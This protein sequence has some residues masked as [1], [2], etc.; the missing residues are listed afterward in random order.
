MGNP[1][2]F[3]RP[4]SVPNGRQIL[5]VGEGR[6]WALVPDVRNNLL[7]LQSLAREGSA[8]AGVY[9]DGR[10][11]L[12]PF[13]PATTQ[14]AILLD[15]QG[16]WHFAVS[17][18]TGLFYQVRDHDAVAAGLARRT[19]LS[20]PAKP[21]L[22]SGQLGDMALLPG[23]DA[24]SL[25]YVQADGS[26]A[27]V[28]LAVRR[29][30]WRHYEM[31]RGQGFRPPALEVAEDRLLLTWSDSAGR[32]YFQ[33]V[34]GTSLGKKPVAPPQVI[35]VPGRRP[36]IMATDT[37]VFVAYED[38]WGQVVALV[39]E[40]EAWPRYPLA[41]TTPRL[42]VDVTHSAHLVRDTHGVVW[43][44]FSDA[45]RR[46]TYFTRWLG[47]QWSEVYDARGIFQ[48]SP[49]F[50]SNLLSADYL[51]VEK[52]P[53]GG[54]IGM[55][56]VNVSSAVATFETVPVV[57]PEARPGQRVLFLDMLEVGKMEG[58]E[59]VLV[60]A[61]KDEANPVFT[62]D[63]DRDAFDHL[64]VF[65][66]GTVLF[67]PA[68]RIYR[69]WYSGMRPYPE[70]IAWWHWLRGGYAESDDGRNWRRINLG[71]AEWNG[72]IENNL[73]PDFPICPCVYRDDADA[74]PRRRYKMLHFL[75]AG[76]QTDLAAAGG[77][78]LDAPYYPG[79][80]YT[81]PDGLR[82]SREPA[83]ITF[84]E[85]R[86]LSFVPQCFFRDDADPDPQ[87]RWKAY[88]FMSV[89]YRR[90]AGGFAYSPEALHWT[91]HPRNPV[92]EPQTSRLPM[93]PAGRLSQI[94]DMVVWREGD[95]YLGLFQDQ[96]SP[97][98]M[99]LELAV[100][101]DGEHFVYPK[102]GEPFIAEGGAGRWDNREL[103]PS[104]PLRVGDE[105][106]FYYGG[107]GPTP[108][109]E[110]PNDLYWT[111]SCGLARSRVEGLT[112]LQPVKEG[113]SGSLTTVPF[114][115]P[116]SCRLTVNAAC[117]PGSVLRVELCS[118]EGKP[119][120]GYGR[121]D[122]QPVSVDSVRTPV[123]WERGPVIAVESQFCIRFFL[124]GA[125][126]RLYAFGFEAEEN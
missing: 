36:S 124:E 91:G 4:A 125:G 30:G 59:Q 52:H 34:D 33:E 102:P 79:F 31:A 84:P 93:I 76:E 18:K 86:P 105:L 19:K 64:R 60:P 81:S 87:R 74:D 98:C 54:D 46:F 69:M 75:N 108:R 96:R 32:I 45:N 35:G 58:V 121:T 21:L 65:N 11:T 61:T 14:S 15:T 8:Q 41:M 119:L 63:Q 83:E 7:G 51:S 107:A 123:T 39:N 62:P 85:G 56:L 5:R 109:I 13:E 28:T 6:W 57:M 111:V 110:S 25:A 43:L 90:R 49:Y 112:C 12:S 126:V 70:S 97:E 94:H 118:P 10:L 95:L 106:W 55:V 115:A 88:G 24:P 40:G 3:D 101:R 22:P 27:V 23:T 99:P 48:R 71:Q 114:R 66:H 37:T 120:P 89:T 68:R 82:W 77:Y 42:T 104:T 80:L 50:D 92:L 117:S 47:R 122:C 29:Q 16:G 20:R 78:D 26:D 72:S 17:D 103:L 113:D 38:W 44:F 73:F 67:D 53:A 116:E 2:F 9:V 1:T 100:S